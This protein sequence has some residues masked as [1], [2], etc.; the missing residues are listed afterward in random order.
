[1]KTEEIVKWNLLS[2]KEK[3]YICSTNTGNIEDILKNVM[4][5]DILIQFLHPHCATFRTQEHINEF[6]AYWSGV[7]LCV[8]VCPHKI[9]YNFICHF[10]IS[11][12]Q[13]TAF[14]KAA[15]MEFYTDY[16]TNLCFVL[17]LI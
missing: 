10:L 1:M 12:L 16:K 14:K 6:L 2:N 7:C 8:S 13:K 17:I 4:F 9:T 11:S 3:P 5:D 15:G